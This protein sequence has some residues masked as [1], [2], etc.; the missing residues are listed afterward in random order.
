VAKVCNVYEQPRRAT[1]EKTTSYD[2]AGVGGGGYSRGAEGKGKGGN[3]MGERERKERANNARK[4]KPTRRDQLGNFE[5]RRGS[6][7]RLVADPIDTSP[8]GHHQVSVLLSGGQTQLTS[9]PSSGLHSSRPH[10]SIVNSNGY[11][12]YNHCGHISIRS[13]PTASAM[14][15]NALTHRRKTK[16]VQFLVMSS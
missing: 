16:R 15:N 3:R 4:K 13:L 12:G 1:K 5:P 11:G 10:Y 14:T 7:N 8:S 9:S 6:V 2:G